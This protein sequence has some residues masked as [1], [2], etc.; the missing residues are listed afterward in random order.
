MS[1]YSSVYILQFFWSS[2]SVLFIQYILVMGRLRKK[3]RRPYFATIFFSFKQ[4][5]RPIQE[6]DDVLL[7]P[8]SFVDLGIGAR[9][10]ADN[11][12][13][14]CRADVSWQR[15][16]RESGA[17]RESGFTAEHTKIGTTIIVMEIIYIDHLCIASLK[18]T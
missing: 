8:S 6:I 17:I 2:S 10:L 13:V 1:E 15:V 11:R 3:K 12:A 18:L 9:S 5:E 4:I 14:I 16:L 7:L